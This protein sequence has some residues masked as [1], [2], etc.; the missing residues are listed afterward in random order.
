MELFSEIMKRR[1]YEHIIR[2]FSGISKEM[3]DWIQRLPLWIEE[4][5]FCRS[6]G[7]NPFAIH[8]T[9]RG[10]AMI[11]RRCQMIKNYKILFVIVSRKS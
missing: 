11:V 9:P 6:A 2:S 7:V 3:I 10:I 4:E 8:E 1:L 5:S